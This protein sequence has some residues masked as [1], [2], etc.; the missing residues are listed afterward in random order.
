MPVSALS[1]PGF[2]GIASGDDAMSRGFHSIDTP[3]AHTDG[4][5]R[6]VVPYLAGDGVGPEI[7][8]HSVRVF[9][10]ALRAAYGGKRSI[11]WQ[12][13]LAGER[14]VAATEQWLPAATIAALQAH[15]TAIRGPV[16]VP[17]G[18]GLRSLDAALAELLGLDA[19][20]R[21]FEPLLGERGAGF[22]WTLIEP[23]AC[24]LPTCFES[25][26]SLEAA[27][28]LR[29]LGADDTKGNGIAVNIEAVERDR[30]KAAVRRAIL[31]ALDRGERAVTL[32]HRDAARDRAED[33]FRQWAL[34]L[35][36][37]CFSAQVVTEDEAR[38]VFGADTVPGKLV[39]RDRAT[40]RVLW[41]LWRR[42]GSHRILVA[43][44]RDGGLLASALAAASG[45]MGFVPGAWLGERHAVFGVPHGTA[46]SLAGR[47]RANPGSL[48]LCGAAL[49][50]QLGWAEAAT[51][52]RKGI[53]RTLAQK[54]VTSDLA[55]RMEGARIVGCR[56]F[57]QHIVQNL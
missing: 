46:P 4:P 44:G 45:S 24:A 57:A 20:A 28:S 31:F 56:E 34:E 52:I 17:R 25:P 49:F 33:A 21:H 27:Q 8:N 50:E 43:T 1:A 54:I 39:L 23:V 19:F 16:S 11:E 5:A 38:Q 22:R 2:V 6:A 3:D 40:D 14:A 18:E 30:L 53:E 26:G 51:R 9:E 35:A 32:V 15:R 47:D 12:E 48:L 10:E 37:E 29:R 41:E 55:E 13:T 7:W 42:P 36:K